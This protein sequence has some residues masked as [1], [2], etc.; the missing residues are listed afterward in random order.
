VIAALTAD[1]APAAMAR[2]FLMISVLKSPIMFL[3]SVHSDALRVEGKIGFMALAGLLISLGNIAFNILLTAGIR[4]GVAGS[5]LGTATAQAVALLVMLVFR[6]TCKARLSAPMPGG[7][8]LASWMGILALGA[9]RSLS[10]LG[11]AL[12]ATATIGRM[13]ARHSGNDE[14]IAASTKIRQNARKAAVVY[15]YLAEALHR[16][17]ELAK[18]DVQ[19]KALRDQLE[20]VLE[21]A[22][23]EV[24][25]AIDREAIELWA[26]AAAALLKG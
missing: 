12:G 5:D 21:T 1:P 4:L 25:D 22:R 11:I 9:P 23:P 8:W 10:F 3:V 14:I 15:I 6:L 18:L 13:P 7:K 19:K 20:A 16:I 24:P 17:G 26:N 2:Q